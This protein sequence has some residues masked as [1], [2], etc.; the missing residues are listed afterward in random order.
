M[1]AKLL[2]LPLAAAILQ[3]CNT[4]SATK[5]NTKPENRNIAVES[6]TDIS[7]EGSHNVYYMQG[8]NTSVK[9]SGCTDD[10]NRMNIYCKNNTLHI[11]RKSK[12]FSILSLLTNP[13]NDIKVYI[14]SPNIRGVYIAGS[15]S[16]YAQNN[17]DT[18]QMTAKVTGSGNIEM[19]D[20]ICNK[21]S[22]SVVGS[23]NIYIEKLTTDKSKISIPGS[24]SI[25]IDCSNINNT[26]NSITGSGYIKIGKANIGQ[27][28][29]HITGSGSI[30]ID[31][32]V[33][34]HK[35]HVTGSGN[36]YIK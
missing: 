36:V 30:D 35:D 1:K 20:I 24:G 33:K 15:G 26:T 17:I 3:A 4:E 5:V 7:I 25:K 19:K 10:I 13:K 31:G 21:S 12:N 16:F 18:D 6:F 8:N 23:G 27:A 32:K 34:V 11:S 22:I 29:N 2:L 28:D 9:V 14:T